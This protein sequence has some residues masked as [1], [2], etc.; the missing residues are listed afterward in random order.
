MKRLAVFFVVLVLVGACGEGDPTVSA[1]G[2]GDTGAE[3]RLERGDQ[4][5]VR[6]TANPSTGYEW[7]VDGSATS[8]FLQQVSETFEPGDTDVV[9]APGHT[10]YIFEAI[11]PGAGVLRLEYM[12]PFDELPIPERIVEY[13]VR[14]G[15]VPWPPVGDNAAPPST[16]TATAPDD[17]PAP[18]QVS[19]LFDGEGPRTAV[20]AGFVVWDDAS[21]R[22]CEVL[23]ESFPPQCGNPWLV[24]ADPENLS[25]ELEEA[26]GVR[27]TQDVVEFEFYYDGNRLVA[28]PG[29][30]G[31]T[32]AQVSLVAAF[33]AFADEPNENTFAGVP[34]ATEVSLGL[35][36]DVLVMV[37]RA[38]L[39]D[40]SVW[41]FED[42]EFRAWSGPFSALEF[43]ED[44]VEITIG[45]HPRCAAPPEPPP[46]GFEDF[47]RVSIQ[48]TD[49]TSCLEWWTVD[50]F[51]NPE[52][53]IGAV[54]LDLYAP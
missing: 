22:L 40:P 10:V 31:P 47:Q 2:D 52:S 11:D 45:A 29:A 48:P 54:T 43:A 53:E 20:V 19:E 37:E 41:S 28:E 8:A 13:L 14:V 49:A 39:V 51:L 36:P 1:V 26:S 25:L 6:L 18:I 50:F 27:W 21:A 9:G 4:L 7:T 15:D 16:A 38:L 3:I 12:R 44:P 23:M 5:E 35:G 42:D 17:T 33:L 46:I 24:I 30:P 32:D 34:F